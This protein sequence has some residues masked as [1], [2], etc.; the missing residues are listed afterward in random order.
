[1]T[2]DIADYILDK[3]SLQDSTHCFCSPF[4]NKQTLLLFRRVQSILHEKA[5]IRVRCAAAV[6]FLIPPSVV[7]HVRYAYLWEFLY[8]IQRKVE[9]GPRCVPQDGRMEGGVLG[10]SSAN[11]DLAD[12][13]D[14]SNTVDFMIIL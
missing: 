12:K 13:S 1:M 7:I 4:K 10:I 14:I 5:L 8:Y 3:I 2:T 6:H 11:A 9:P